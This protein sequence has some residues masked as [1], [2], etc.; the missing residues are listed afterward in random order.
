MR[1]RGDDRG[2]FKVHWLVKA[3]LAIAIL[4]VLGYDGFVTIATH[5][6]AENDAQNAAYAASQFWNDDP[7][8]R[9]SIQQVFDAAVQYE[10]LNNPSEHVCAGPADMVCDGKGHFSID[11]DGTVHLVIRR[12][13][14]TIN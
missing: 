8:A 14:K 12:E 9:S 7:E 5:L 11:A 2:A 3:G 13:A 6:K 4:G 1:I 10:K